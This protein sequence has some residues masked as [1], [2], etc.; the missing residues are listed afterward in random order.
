[1]S[2]NYA[3]DTISPT[4]LLPCCSSW[5]TYGHVVFNFHTGYFLSQLKPPPGFFPRESGHRHKKD[6]VGTLLQH[7]L[8]I[9]RTVCMHSGTLT[10]SMWGILLWLKRKNVCA[11]LNEALHRDGTALNL[12][13]CLLFSGSEL[14]SMRAWYSSVL[15]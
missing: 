4:V 2:H 10:I 6:C 1:M 13:K 11:Y 8:G 5:K 15:W 9:S 14:M 3:H 12:S 7:I